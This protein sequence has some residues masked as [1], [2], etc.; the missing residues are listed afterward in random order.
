MADVHQEK[1]E[2]KCSYCK[3]KAVDVV[4]CVK[5][6]ASYHQSC[7]Q[8][9]KIEIS[10]VKFACCYGTNKSEVK[11]QKQRKHSEKSENLP[12]IAKM[13]EEKLKAII[14]QCFQQFFSPVEKKMDQKLNSLERSVQFMSNEFEQ[15]K[16]AYEDALGEIKMLKKDNVQLKQRIQ[17]L[18]ST[19]DG[20]EQHER[21]NNLIIVG[22]P[23]QK[24]PNLHKITKKICKAMDVTLEDQDI[25][26]CYQLEKGEGGRILVKFESQGKKR[27]IMEQVRQRRGITVRGCNLEG[28]DGKLYLNDD[29]TVYKRQL[30]QKARELKSRFKLRAVYTSNGNIFL[31]KSEGDRPI[32]IKSEQDLQ[33]LE[34]SIK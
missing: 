5:C 14:K 10:G 4:Q 27:Q 25:K 7:S 21:A 19:L 11:Q 9:V 13:D 17:L 23:K 12:E 30:F 26:E 22:V 28:N 2:K 33:N 1:V 31:K 6:N 18:E 15:Q 16:K 24:E 29:M 32:K 3:K 34:N 8:R 20:I